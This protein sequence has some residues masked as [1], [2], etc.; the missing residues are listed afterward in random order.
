MSDERTS[1]PLLHFYKVY[2]LDRTGSIKSSTLVMA[3]N[4]T[5][6]LQKAGRLGQ[7]SEIEVWD[8]SR[9]VGTTG[10]QDVAPTYDVGAK[11]ET[12]ALSS[13]H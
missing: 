12:P 5:D 1:G 8:R 13:A 2:H 3:L 6:A 11:P 7:Q 9:F 4:D 10:P